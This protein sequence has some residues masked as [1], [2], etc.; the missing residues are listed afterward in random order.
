MTC[1][2][3]HSDMQ[4]RS[5]FSHY[6]LKPYRICPDCQARYTTDARSKKRSLV[7]AILAVLTIALSVAGFTLGFPWGLAALLG[8]TGCLVY[9]GFVLS[10]MEYVEYVD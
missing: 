4:S 6:S 2:I 10:K 7:G 3:C 8:G 5:L 1:P 9:A